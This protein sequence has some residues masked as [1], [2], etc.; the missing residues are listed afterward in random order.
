MALIQDIRG[1]QGGLAERVSDFFAALAEA[2]ARRAVYRQTLRELKALSGRE[3]A[4]LGIPRSTIT[5]VALEA[6]YGK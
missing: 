3:L 4:D 2:R 6:A 5:R 1:A